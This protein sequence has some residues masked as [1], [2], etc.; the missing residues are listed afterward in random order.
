MAPGGK[1]MTRKVSDIDFDFF[2]DAGESIPTRNAPQEP[3]DFKDYQRQTKTYTDCFPQSLETISKKPLA[4]YL[5]DVLEYSET[6][7]EDDKESWHSPLFFFARFAKAHPELINLSDA[8]A[9]KHVEN[10]MRSWPDL[11]RGCD[12][13]DYYFC[14]EDA[15]AARID[16]ANC[17]NSIRHIPFRDP[18]QN[19]LRQA[20]RAPLTPL[21]ERGPLYERFISMAGWLQKLQYGKDI[22]LPTRL[23]A[24]LLCCDQRTVSRL[25]KL[26]LCDGLL[27]ITGEHEFRSTGKSKATAFRFA[28]ERFE[29]G[30]K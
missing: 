2:E 11:P 8:Q 9:M 21:N 27:R 6:S 22:Y 29:K 12:P 1:K 30:D 23:V 28:I 13:W 10:A 24:R 14:A 4:N 7:R 16:F 5:R 20:E 26:A 19:A 3:Q 15:D 18:L 25:R 17:W